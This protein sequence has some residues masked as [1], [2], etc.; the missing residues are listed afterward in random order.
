[1]SNTINS[2]NPGSI[3]S[4]EANVRIVVGIALIL[5]IIDTTNTYG[6]NLSYPILIGCYVVLTGIASW[7]PVNAVVKSVFTKRSTA[8]EIAGNAKLASA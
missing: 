6:L 5:S 8:K 2:Q 7:D 3:K 1:M 4:S